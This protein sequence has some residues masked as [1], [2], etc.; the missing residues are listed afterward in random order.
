M[1]IYTVFSGGGGF[2][3]YTTNTCICPMSVGTSKDST[4]EL[5]LNLIVMVVGDE[6]TVVVVVVVFVGVVC[7]LN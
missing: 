2:P 3:G 7:D 6:F 1:Y 4:G 5:E